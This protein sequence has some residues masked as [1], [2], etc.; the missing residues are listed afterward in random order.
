[1]HAFK[2]ELHDDHGQLRNEYNSELVDD[3][4]SKSDHEQDDD[5]S[6]S[7]LDE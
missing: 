1:M 6:N 3:I 5:L 4:E 7:L 2:R